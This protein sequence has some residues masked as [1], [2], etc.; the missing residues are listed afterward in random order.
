M[1]L[2][3]DS[4]QIARP[5]KDVWRLLGRPELWMEGYLDTMQ[6]SPDYPGPDT[7][8]DHVFRTQVREHVEARVTRSEPPSLLEEEQRGRSFSRDVRYRLE[9][10]GDRTRLTVEDEISF[11]GIARMA[12]PF[13]TP[14]VR[15][16][17]SRSL[18]RLR[19]EA[20]RG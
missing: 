19:A 16:R 5:P 4:I 18:D 20:E 15:R 12:S 14:D 7:R 17:W 6:R 3:T 10:A 8:N 9:P 11:I 13:A 2:V 1:P